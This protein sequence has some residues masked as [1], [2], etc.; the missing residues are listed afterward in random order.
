LILSIHAYV[1]YN[2]ALDKD[3][4]K[5]TWSKSNQSDISGITG[6]IDRAYNKFTNKGERVPVIIG[7]FGA[8]NKNN[9]AVRAE[10]AKFYVE[11]AGNKGMPCFWWDNGVTSGDG[12]KFGLLNRA[13]NNFIYPDVVAAMTGKKPTNNPNPTR[14]VTLGTKEDGTWRGYY[15]LGDFLNGVKITQGNTYTF[16]YT[17]TSDVA[18]DSL[19]VLLYDNS[20]AAGDWNVLAGSGPWITDL[21]SS[22]QANTARSGTKTFTAT[23]TATDATGTANRILFVTGSGTASAPTLTF[24]E[25]KFEKNGN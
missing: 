23:D 8:M 11:Y 4:T 15:E 13:T 9:E 10:W 18:V 21:E 19:G 1:P 16:T 3:L 12:E 5:N 7:E 24:S 17:F 20:P 14:T 2:F 22:I 25:F 6:P